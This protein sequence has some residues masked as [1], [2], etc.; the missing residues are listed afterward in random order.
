MKNN[1]LFYN[2]EDIKTI[3][4]TN[5]NNNIKENNIISKYPL[6]ENRKNNFMHN[7]ILYK[8]LG[9]Q[10]YSICK[11]EVHPLLNEFNMA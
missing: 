7:R 9:R 10:N 3:N 1:F 2:N 8:Q 5:T 11:N 4:K 6:N